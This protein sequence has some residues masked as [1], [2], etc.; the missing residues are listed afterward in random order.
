MIHPTT[1]E[2]VPFA[3]LAAF[4]ED[5]ASGNPALVV[6][7]PPEL[8]SR[9]DGTTQQAIAAN[10]A[11]PMAAFVVPRLAQAGV[12]DVRFFTPTR[13]SAICGHATLCAAAALFADAARVPPGVEELRFEGKTATLFARKAEG[14]RIEIALG[15]G[16][17]TELTEDD[18]RTA[19]LRVTLK[20]ALGESVGVVY[21]GTGPPHL[22]RYTL[23]EIDTSDLA[24]LEVDT[25]ALRQSPFGMYIFTTRSKDPKYAFLSR[26]FDPAAGIPEDPVCGSAHTLLAPYWAAKD[27][28]DTKLDSEGILAHQVSSRGGELKVSRDGGLIKLTGK[29]VT[30][31]KGE[32]FV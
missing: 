13:E 31:A 6:F 20:K 28:F 3:H 8:V 9:V 32:V 24:S 16:E 19:Q 1:R 17:V 21:A 10:F 29:V 22:A 4:A 5:I 2:S 23:I 11:Q 14:G 7:L 30:L 18:P 15:A 12:F 25:Q 26:V 27:G